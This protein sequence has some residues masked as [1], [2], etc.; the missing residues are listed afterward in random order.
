LRRARLIEGA[1]P[2]P[3]PVPATSR[4]PA[5]TDDRRAE[6]GSDG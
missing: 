2:P 3:T 4:Q 5:G 1:L 6:G